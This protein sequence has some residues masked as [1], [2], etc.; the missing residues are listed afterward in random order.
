MCMSEFEK[1][2]QIHNINYSERYQ[3]KDGITNFYRQGMLYSQI[4][5]KPKPGLALFNTACANWEKLS[6]K[7]QGQRHQEKKNYIK[8]L[9]QSASLLLD[10]GNG[11]GALERIKK[12]LE[13]DEQTNTIVCTMSEWFS[14]NFFSNYVA[15]FFCCVIFF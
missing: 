7:E 8:S 2:S 12:Y 6:E 10:A 9:Y 15:T 13:Q 3:F 11:F 5:N 1:L 14:L 4:E